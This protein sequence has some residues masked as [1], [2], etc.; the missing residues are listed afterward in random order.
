[1][2]MGKTIS[3]KSEKETLFKVELIDK[4]MQFSI[5]Y[6]NALAKIIKETDIPFLSDKN[7]KNQEPNK[8]PVDII[9]LW[10]KT[11]QQK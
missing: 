3:E 7:I 5:Q 2:T 4:L 9:S 10:K 8:K 11:G 1:M 6:E